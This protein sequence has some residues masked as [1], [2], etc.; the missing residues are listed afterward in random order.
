VTSSFFVLNLGQYLHDA[1]QM[2]LTEFVEEH[3]A[4]CLLVE[5][6]AA[7]EEAH[8]VTSA[9]EEGG[10]S[11]PFVVSIRSRRSGIHGY[12]DRITLGRTG[13]NDVVI[14]SSDIS[15]IHGFFVREGEAISYVDAHSTYGSKVGGVE[16]RPGQTLS[17]KDG[18]K[19]ELASIRATF[20][21]PSGLYAHL[22]TLS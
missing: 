13:N 18:A 7:E 11:V 14:K 10:G 15:K 17:L 16:A 12:G 1:S 21:T 2:T 3:P 4:P 19:L 6:F 20:F 22:N 9:G 5:P 8:L